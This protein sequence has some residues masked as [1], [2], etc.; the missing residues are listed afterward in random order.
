[1]TEKT[2]MQ[3]AIEKIDLQINNPAF[4]GYQSGLRLAKQLLVNEL[5][6]ERQNLI[7]SHVEIMKKGLIEEGQ[8]KWIEGYE[9]LIR[10]TATD[11]VKEKFGI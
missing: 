7:D 9:P 3:I 5:P 11:Y 10:Q 2:A 4:L 8:Q 1:M 6:K